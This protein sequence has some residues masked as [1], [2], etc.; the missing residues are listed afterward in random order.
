MTFLL[1]RFLLL[2]FVYVPVAQIV[3]VPYQ[4]LTVKA[5]HHAMLESLF[6]AE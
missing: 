2:Q 6:V 5:G 3:R 1:R 4:F